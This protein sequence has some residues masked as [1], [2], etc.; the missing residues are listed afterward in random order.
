MDGRRLFL[1]QRAVQP[2]QSSKDGSK[3]PQARVPVALL[4]VLRS[5]VELEGARSWRAR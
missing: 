2:T 3:K 1:F 4:P 5:F